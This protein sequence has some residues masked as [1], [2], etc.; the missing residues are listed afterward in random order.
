MQRCW[1]KVVVLFVSALDAMR[2]SVLRGEY[3][4]NI[5]LSDYQF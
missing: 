3:F 1:S 5:P 2:V 4:C